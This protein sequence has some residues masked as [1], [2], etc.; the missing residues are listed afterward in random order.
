METNSAVNPRKAFTLDLL[1]WMKS[2]KSCGELFI[3][4]GNFNETLHSTSDVIKLCYDDDLQL[5]DALRDLTN[6]QF[7][8]MKT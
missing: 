6:S 2:V 7:S 8:T 3:L 4:G 1:W 5:V